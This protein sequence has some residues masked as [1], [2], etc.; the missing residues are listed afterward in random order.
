MLSGLYPIRAEI[1]F[2]PL[3]DVE[4]VSLV[5]LRREGA[6]DS[7]RLL[8]NLRPKDANVY[9][10][11]G[12]PLRV[13]WGPN[14]EDIQDE[15]IGYVHSYRPVND[16]Y[17]E[18]TMV[19]AVS[20]AYPMVNETGRSYYNMGI[21]NVAEEICD[22]YRF[23][24]D[25]DAHH[26]IQDQ[27][28]QQD[29]SDWT[30]LGRLA[31]RWG[32]VLYLDGVTLVFRRRADVVRENGRFAKRLHTSN[33]PVVNASNIIDFHPNFS[34]TGENPMSS[35][36]GQGVQPVAARRF[37]W[38][39]SKS[40]DDIFQRISTTNVQHEL[41]GEMTTHA[42]EAKSLFPYTASATF[43]HPTGAKPLHAY[44]ITHQDRTMTWSVHSVRHV[45]GN[46]RYLG[47][48]VLGTD[49]SDYADP[50]GPNRGMDVPLLLSRNRRLA[51]PPAVLTRTRGIY[52]GA[53]A[54][55]VITEERWKAR[56]KHR[57]VW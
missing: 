12:S 23:D 27:I 56:I 53:G 14:G 28:L 42:A 9:I 21:H 17:L 5:C 20:P 52:S 38:K 13:R 16:A 45:V 11:A 48:M 57:E 39:E 15:F 19:L 50:Q 33:L 36:V 47:E 4:G 31:D 6:M 26:L 40:G 25:G 35:S 8:L 30:F 41:E 3:S 54:N 10:A 24:L 18:Q 32:Y 44:R 1:P 55:A 22:D 2:T 46:G 49:G 37:A 43:M 7:M 51:R 34:M 29:D